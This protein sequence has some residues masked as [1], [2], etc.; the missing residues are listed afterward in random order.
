MQTRKGWQVQKV[1]SC[2][3]VNLFA[4]QLDFQFVIAIDRLMTGDATALHA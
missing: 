4:N 1:D 3:E 2:E